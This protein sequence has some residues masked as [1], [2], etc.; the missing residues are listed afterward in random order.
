[1]TTNPT[2]RS[3]EDWWDDHPI[4]KKFYVPLV[5]TA[6]FVVTAIDAL[7]GRTHK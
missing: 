6:T 2:R 5:L 3:F 7:G 4:L 1:M